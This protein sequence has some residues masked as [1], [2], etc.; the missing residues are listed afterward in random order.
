MG[1]VASNAT[2][3]YAVKDS[4]TLARNIKV[5]VPPSQSTSNSFDVVG[6]FPN[7]SLAVTIQCLLEMLASAGVTQFVIQD[8]EGLLEIC[9]NLILVNTIMFSTP[10][11]KEQGCPL[12]PL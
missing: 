1:Q 7:I 3:S 11:Q 5:V 8:F 9:N 10:S 12:C 6:L 2:F 4:I